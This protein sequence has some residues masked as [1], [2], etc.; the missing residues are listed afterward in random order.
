MRPICARVHTFLPL[1][2]RATTIALAIL[3]STPCLTTA[4]PLFLQF[5]GEVAADVVTLNYNLPGHPT[6][7]GQFYAGQD[8]ATVSANSDLSNG[9]TFN[10][11][12][13]DL[14]HDVNNGQIYPV[15]V[16]STDNALANGGAVAYLYQTYGV[17]TLSDADYA[18]ALQLAIWDE[19]AN[20]G[21]GQ[22][23]TS[24]LQYSIPNQ[25]VADD[26]AFFLSDAN[27]HTASGQWLQS[28]DNPVG[29]TQGQGFLIPSSQ[30]VPE[31]STIV[32]A[33][34]AVALAGLR[35]RRS[36]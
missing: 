36:R 28:V 20:G 25:T 4:A 1:C 15:N 30:P 2:L 29:Y 10:T 19:V 27:A 34:L 3:A 31:P 12:C 8:S 35:Y 17:G 32:L 21:Q 16:L 26:L 7:N 33:A 5:N 11:F 13:V 18:A 9:M 6:L 22:S 24:P 14:D 23:P